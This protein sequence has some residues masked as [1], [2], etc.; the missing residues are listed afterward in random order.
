MNK[1][2][3]GLQKC[4]SPTLVWSPISDFRR[5]SQPAVVA[6]FKGCCR[7]HDSRLKESLDVITARELTSGKN[8]KNVVLYPWSLCRVCVCM[9]YAAIELG[10]AGVGVDSASKGIHS[11][12]CRMTHRQYSSSSRCASILLA[13]VSSLRYPPVTGASEQPLQL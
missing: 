12:V 8:H 5:R 10:G 2:A 7:S 13:T 11:P 6:C 1:C 4:T 9:G 3:K